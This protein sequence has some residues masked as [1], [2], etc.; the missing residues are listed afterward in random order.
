ME[1]AKQTILDM[2]RNDGN[3]GTAAQFEH[4]APDTVDTDRDSEL[5]RRHGIDLDALSGDS[6][7]LGDPNPRT[8][9]T[10]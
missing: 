7:G 4:E 6:A 5:L 1:I 9:P 8:E 10:D 2:L 3:E